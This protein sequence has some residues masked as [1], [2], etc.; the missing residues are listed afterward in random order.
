MKHRDWCQAKR[1]VNIFLSDIH[2]LTKYMHFAAPEV[3]EVH[4]WWHF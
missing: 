4:F 1:S 2:P 3:G